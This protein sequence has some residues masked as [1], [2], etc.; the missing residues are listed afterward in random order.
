VL[1]TYPTPCERFA[2]AQTSG[3]ELW[4]KR[5]DRSSAVYGGSKVR[6]LE[7]LLAIARARG[8]KRLVTLGAAGSHHVLATAIFGAQAGFDVAAVL[9]PQPRTD[10]AVE[11]LR[12]AIGAGLRPIASSYAGVPLHLAGEI[13][14]GTHFVPFGGS[15]PAGARAFVAATSELFAQVDRGELPEPDEIVV[16]LGSGGTTAGLLAGLALSGRKTRLVAVAVSQPV[17]VVRGYALWLAQR[18]VREQRREGD[19]DLAARLEVV[20]TQLGRGYGHATEDGERATA[21]GADGGL[22]L[23]PTY[24]AKTFAVSLQRAAALTTKT[25]L[26]WHT[27]SSASL[28]PWLARGP[29]EAELPR[30]LRELF[31]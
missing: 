31:T 23:D 15:S 1:G 28:A 21:T 13:D 2:L 14:L 8:A 22:L 25:I 19:V 3:S 30:E 18:L 12:A 29:R 17:L 10:H 4:I 7:P 20:E 16:T 24:T 9:V 27:L 6:K 26:Y 11:D 5:D